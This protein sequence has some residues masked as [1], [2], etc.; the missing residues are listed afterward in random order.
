MNTVLNAIV[1]VIILGYALFLVFKGRPE[2]R[3]MMALYAVTGLWATI[4]HGAVLY[5]YLVRDFLPWQTVTLYLIKPLIFILLCTV[6]AAI[7]KSGW[8]YDD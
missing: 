7:I 3:S 1:S 2:I 4:V 6:L 8:R 5:D